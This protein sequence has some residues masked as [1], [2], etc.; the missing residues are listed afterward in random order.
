M[1]LTAA[2]FAWS[3]A[4]WALH[5]GVIHSVQFLLLLLG[6]LGAWLIY[7]AFRKRFYVLVETQDESRKLAFAA[8][9]SRTEVEA[10]AERLGRVV[11]C[12]IRNALDG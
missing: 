7:A 10:F 4:H 5:G 2:A 6:P 1:I 11:S 3:I 12:P 8:T 9:A